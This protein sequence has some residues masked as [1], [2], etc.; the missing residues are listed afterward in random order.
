M[1]PMD[2]LVK[3]GASNATST[4]PQHVYFSKVDYKTLENNVRKLA[5]KQFPYYT[6][7]YIDSVVGF[8]M[9]NYGPNSGLEDAIKPGFAVIDVGAIA[10]CN[11]NEEK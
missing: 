8:E 9:L 2:L 7:K 10:D 1:D 5:K 11:E 3:L 6:K 4:F